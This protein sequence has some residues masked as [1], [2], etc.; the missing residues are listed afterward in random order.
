MQ[1]NIRQ[2]T[3]YGRVSGRN[4]KMPASTFALHT[5]ACHVGTK[6]RA[7]E[8]STCAKCY[9]T[10][11]ERMYPTVDVGH[12]YNTNAANEHIAS[13]PELWAQAMALQISKI[14]AK[15]N[16]PYHRWFDSGDLQDVAM[17]KAIV[18]VCELTPA[19]HHWLPTR[20]AK[21]L[22]DYLA[23]GHS[24]P[25]NLVIRVSSTMIDDKPIAGHA[26]TS[27]VHRK[28][29]PVHGQSCDAA[30]RG[31]V[32]GPCRA[33]WNPAIANVSYPLHS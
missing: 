1:L 24:L 17:L 31:H 20:E 8:G 2:A 33:C 18:R 14:C 11:F 3:A 27:T 6:L 7:V 12:R 4:S 23:A 25:S 10:K 22:R 26:H 30:S 15:F 16:E 28:A 9:A 29:S 13:N 32:C 19:I 5:N 21:I